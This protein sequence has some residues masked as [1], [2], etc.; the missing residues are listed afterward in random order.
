ME[1]LLKISFIT[2]IVT[3]LSYQCGRTL[4]A[5]QLFLKLDIEFT[6]Y[7]SM[8]FDGSLGDNT[9]NKKA[10]VTVI[11]NGELEKALS[12]LEEFGFSKDKCMTAILKHQPFFT[13]DEYM[14]FDFDFMEKLLSRLS[15]EN[16]P[17][18]VELFENG[19][20]KKTAY[21]NIEKHHY[22]RRLK[23]KYIEENENTSHDGFFS[24]LLSY[25]L[26]FIFILCYGTWTAIFP[27]NMFKPV[28]WCSIEQVQDYYRE[29]TYFSKRTLY[30]SLCMWFIVIL[31][32]NV[33]SLSSWY[34]SLVETDILTI[35][36]SFVIFF[37]AELF[38]F[39]LYMKHLKDATKQTQEPHNYEKNAMIAFIFYT[40]IKAIMRGWKKSLAMIL[41][42][43][44]SIETAKSLIIIIRYFMHA[45]ETPPIQ[46]EKKYEII[47]IDEENEYKAIIQPPHSNKHAF[48]Y[49]EDYDINEIVE[50]IQKFTHPIINL[51]YVDSK[52]T[53]YQSQL[54]GI[55]YL[56]KGQKLPTY[57]EE[58]LMLLAQINCD[59][60]EENELLPHH[61]ILQFFIRNDDVYGCDFDLS[62]NQVKFKVIYHEYVDYDE[63]HLQDLSNYKFE[64]SPILKPSAFTLTIKQECCL[65][66]FTPH[67]SSLI[68]E[69]CSDLLP[70][71]F[72]NDDSFWSD[73][74]YYYDNQFIQNKIG[75][76]GF[77]TQDDPR[78][79]QS[80][81]FILL[82]LISDEKHLMFGD[83]GTCH[84][85]ISYEDLKNLNFE[86]VTYD[87]DCY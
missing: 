79:Y 74:T 28:R 66:R 83:S 85:F 75:G 26:I 62:T 41:L 58:P 44:V 64:D 4:V 69:E 56:L 54:G 31:F 71:H 50:R 42:L 30:H 68:K 3:F 73:L 16:I 19:L 12:V 76:I 78:I 9:K 7:Q 61:G 81:S 11:H 23:T 1:D 5:K 2:F 72:E 77:F 36:F 25:T 49:H 47:D 39:P 29:F 52:P 86:S 17:F 40:I 46:S 60:L 70:D 15:Y 80:R 13:F 63:S 37:I 6:D 45:K 43:I 14:F 55:P 34:C 65:D 87:W 59:E 53:R 10:R 48:E 27:Y 32:L 57:N 33:P 8:Y 18:S 21:D 38:V 67:A 82:Q 84:F 51:E 20:W 35:Q 24:N 22:I